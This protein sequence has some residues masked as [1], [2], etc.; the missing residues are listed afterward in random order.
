MSNKIIY[1]GPTVLGVAARNTVFDTIPET[2]AN[3]P[4]PVYRSLCISLSSYSAAAAQIKGKDGAFY[5]FYK[6]A[7]ISAE[8]KE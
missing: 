7:L 5:E 4:D 8:R 1:I 6:Q 3:A 2:I